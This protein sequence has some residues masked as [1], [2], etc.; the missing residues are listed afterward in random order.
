MSD[1]AYLFLELSCQAA[2]PFNGY[3]GLVQPESVLAADGAAA[4]RKAIAAR[5]TIEALWVAGEKI[6]GANVLTC[7]VVVR[8]GIQSRPSLLKRSRGASFVTYEPLHQST[9]EIEDLSTWGPLISE[10]FGIPRIDLPE[11]CSPLGDAVSATA[12]FR[13]QYYGLAPFVREYDEEDCAK[14]QFVPLITVGL[15]DPMRSRWGAS[16]TKFNKRHWIAPV[17]DVDRLRA[18]SNLGDWVDQRLVPKLLVATQSKVIEVLPDEA[19]TLLPSVP[20]ISVVP[21]KNLLVAC[22]GL[23]ELPCSHCMVGRALPWGLLEH[24]INQAER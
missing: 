6:F 15:I 3:V 5:S 14:S 21:S 20:V 12:D 1:S 23:A 18:S 24:F 19:G 16:P 17:V 10:C 4:L 9:R 7:F 13:D 8:N 2:R 11:D 22:C